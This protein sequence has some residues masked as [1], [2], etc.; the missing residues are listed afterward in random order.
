MHTR[1]PIDR[2]DRPATT[3]DE[4]GLARI[5]EE[6][7]AIPAH[8][9][10]A[11]DTAPGPSLAAALHVVDDGILAKGPGSVRSVPSAGAIFPYDV[12]VLDRSGPGPAVL[13]RLNLDR[14]LC[15]RTAAGAPLAEALAG[16]TGSDRSVLVL[17]A[18]RPWLSIR[19][20]GPRGYLYAQIDAGHAATN[21]LGT[22][23]DRGTARLRLAL[24]RRRLAE[25]LADHLPWREVHSV[26]ELDAPRTP[27]AAPPDGW[28]YLHQEQ[29]APLESAGYLE[30]VCWARIPRLLA[31]GPDHHR[32]TTRTVVESGPLLPAAAGIEPGEWTGLSRRRRSSKRFGRQPLDP[33]VLLDCVGALMTA[34]PCDLTGSGFGV[35]VLTPPG[36]ITAPGD[37]PPG[38]P[39]FVGTAFVTDTAAIARACTGQSHLAGADAFV[40]LHADRAS[41]LGTGPDPLREAVFRSA[42][43][44]HLLYLGAA[45]NAVGVTGVGGFDA[46]QWLAAAGLD[47]TREL[48][49]VV[50]LGN[51]R[52]DARKLDRAEIAYAQGE[53]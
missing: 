18:V 5:W 41:T 49:Y 35:T 33:A 2:L 38:A 21:L 8:P 16:T 43:A 50:A 1:D 34:L 36:R 42:A 12:L 39:D 10:L 4:A 51:D 11:A 25:A 14:R 31:D 3:A 52:D 44:A 9:E 53:R 6:L 45:R 26:L 20:Y 40:L 23:L 15:V 17:L 13:Y 29:P 7:T 22:A 48:L 47:H 46:A 32:L 24:P 28:S 19:K 27:A 37:N 30:S